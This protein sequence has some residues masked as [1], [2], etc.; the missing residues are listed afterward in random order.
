MDNE[1]IELLPNEK[2]FGSDMIAGLQEGVM[3]TSIFKLKETSSESSYTTFT[4]YFQTRAIEILNANKWLT[5]RLK[6][7][8]RPSK[9]LALVVD[10]DKINQESLLDY[11]VIETDENVVK[12]CQN[13]KDLSY[14]SIKSVVSKYDV[15]H[16]K[17]LWDKEDAKMCRFGQI[18]NPEKTICYMFI[19]ISHVLTDGYSVYRIWRMFDPKDNVVSLSYIR[20]QDFV[21]SLKTETSLLPVDCSMREL[22]SKFDYVAVPAFAMKGISQAIKKTTFKGCFYKLNQDF[23]QKEKHKY[24]DEDGFV[25]TNDIIT[26]W[27]AGLIKKHGQSKIDK[28]IMYVDCR[29]RIPG[30][31]NDMVGNYITN[32]VMQKKDMQT[33][34]DVRKWVQTITQKDNSWSFPSFSD[35]RKFIGCFHTNWVKF[36]HH[37]NF[38]DF[39]HV[40]HFPV[41]GDLDLQLG[42]GIPVGLEINII[43]FKSNQT[44]ICCYLYTRRSDIDFEKILEEEIIDSVL[45]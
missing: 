45:M 9:R 34:K 42:L 37:L 11:I 22:Y 35:F 19:V 41:F 40:L 12:N 5:S 3:I 39:E 38:D 14:D 44:D 43:I 16:A 18:W 7:L 15:G 17:D 27:F 13:S 32:P 8:K 4:E 31:E 21:N 20:N 25:S 10:N 1:I 23:I 29:G 36:Y 30:I 28:I 33:P 2:A 26:S 6:H 24:S